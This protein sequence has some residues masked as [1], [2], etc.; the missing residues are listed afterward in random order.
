MGFAFHQDFII[1]TWIPETS[2]ASTISYSIGSY[3]LTAEMTL[4]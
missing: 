4:M 1:V 2:Y 3:V